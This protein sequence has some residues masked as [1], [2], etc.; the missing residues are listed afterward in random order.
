M[1]AFMTGSHVYGTPT[2]KSDIDL[3]VLMDP[4]EL[5]RLRVM[6]DYG[7]DR[8]SY[9]MAR[10]GASLRFGSLNLIVVTTQEQFDAWARARVECQTLEPCDRDT[11]KAIHKK[12]R[13][14]GEVEA[15]P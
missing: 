10:D 2:E 6:S 5:D 8:D 14:R 12:H 3:V 15:A 13:T 1:T 7:E 11:A 4:Q 9:V